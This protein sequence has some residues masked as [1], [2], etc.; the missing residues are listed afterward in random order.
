MVVK[1]HCSI[2]TLNSNIGVAR[3]GKGSDP[4]VK[5][6]QKT[7]VYLVFLNLRV[8]QYSRTTAINN[9]IDNHGARAPSIQFCQP[10]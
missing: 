9:N 10:I 2:Q 7:L 4:V 8:L 6:W 1:V 3:G 5:M